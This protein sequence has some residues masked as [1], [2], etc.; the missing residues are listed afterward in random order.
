MK[1]TELEETHSGVGYTP[2]PDLNGEWNVPPLRRAVNLE[3]D[4]KDWAK[5]SDS[6]WRSDNPDWDNIEKV[7][8]Y[9][10]GKYHIIETEQD[11][12]IL[13]L[14]EELKQAEQRGIDK[15]IGDFRKIIHRCPRYGGTG[16]ELHYWLHEPTLLKE[17]EELKPKK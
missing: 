4:F 16:T 9:V 3:R 13:M 14:R 15:A 10:I 17:L 8:F 11:E 6:T 2:E 5:E 1:K 12:K 7:T